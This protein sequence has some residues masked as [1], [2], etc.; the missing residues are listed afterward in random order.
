M[1]IKKLLWRLC[2]SLSYDVH[3]LLVISKCNCMYMYN[4]YSGRS[5]LKESRQFGCLHRGDSGAYSWSFENG[6][7]PSWRQKVS[8]V[9]EVPNVD[10]YYLARNEEGATAHRHCC[11][12][13]DLAMNQSPLWPDFWI[14]HN[15]TIVCGVLFKSCR[16]FELFKILF[17]NSTAGGHE[18]FH[19]N[20]ALWITWNSK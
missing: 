8:R 7:W 2:S 4:N 18:C 14:V 6:Q 5:Q 20:I 9:W 10:V 17:S 3:V 12:R 1:K 11:V 13:E 15:W 19:A 16:E